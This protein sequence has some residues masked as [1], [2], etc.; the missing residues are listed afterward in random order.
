MEDEK[1]IKPELILE[2]G[3]DQTEV[4]DEFPEGVIETFKRNAVWVSICKMIDE[5]N[6]SL[7]GLML[8][9]PPS[10]VIQSGGIDLMGIEYFQ[11][12]VEECENFKT[13]PDRLLKDKKQEEI[14][15]DTNADR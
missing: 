2:E 13:L 12:C 6:E 14:A 8:T 9:C 15:N 10:R 4:P 7:K 5:H 1:G 11:G 3:S